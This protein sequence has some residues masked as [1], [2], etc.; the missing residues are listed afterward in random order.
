MAPGEPTPRPPRASQPG[1]PPLHPSP[2]VI[3]TPSCPPCAVWCLQS[4]PAW[5][6]QQME[7]FSLK[8]PPLLPSWGFSRF[9]VQPCQEVNQPSLE[10][11]PGRGGRRGG[12]RRGRSVSAEGENSTAALSSEP[13]LGCRPTWFAEA[14]WEGGWVGGSFSPPCSSSQGIRT[15][16]ASAVTGKSHSISRKESKV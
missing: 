7:C 1:V 2:A 14:G 15:S 13:F 16:P 3:S 10:P 9:R 8:M 11:A 6:W 12:T 5:G 4:H